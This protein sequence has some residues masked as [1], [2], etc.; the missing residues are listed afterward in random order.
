MMGLSNRFDM[1][2]EYSYL[3]LLR[4]RGM[5]WI[6]FKDSRPVH[7]G[8]QGANQWVRDPVL[9][10]I[11]LSREDD[12][13]RRTLLQQSQLDAAMRNARCRCCLG[14]RTS[15]RDTTRRLGR[16]AL[17]IVAVPTFVGSCMHR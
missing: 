4:M 2:P 8:R 12:G 13:T 15:R 6:P 16:V 5:D 1:A 7:L 14:S 17:V 3:G 11:V 10:I 9:S